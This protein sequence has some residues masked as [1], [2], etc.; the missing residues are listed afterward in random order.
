VF[1]PDTFLPVAERSGLINLIDRWVVT[2]AINLIGQQSALGRE[3]RLSV[4]LSGKAFADREL[5]PMIQRQI[6]AT[7]ADPTHLVFEITES[8]VI[9]DLSNA[10]RF[11]QT[12][13]SLGA[14]F[15]LD[16]FG[17]GFSSFLY[18]K[19]LPVDYLKIDGSFIVNLP[20]DAIDQHLVRSM[21]QLAHDLG[22]KT[23]AEFVGSAETIRL[24]EEYGID[25]VQGYFVGPPRSIWDVVP[26]L[27][28]RHWPADQTK[29]AS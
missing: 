3:L 14:Q 20:N 18:L 24:L 25:Y 21:A 11:M 13:K 8:T 28:V 17:V 5:L 16:D 6:S 27:G 26:R 23:V 10:Q 2:K 29:R 7:G 9:A 1:A 15:A 4:N 19:Q 12:L 22:K